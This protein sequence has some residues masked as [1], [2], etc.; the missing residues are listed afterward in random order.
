MR[1]AIRLFIVGWIAFQNGKKKGTKFPW[2]W[3]YFLF[4]NEIARITIIIYF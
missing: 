3:N 1:I 2:I 4:S